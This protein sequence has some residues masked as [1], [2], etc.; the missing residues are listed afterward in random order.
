M[1]T[2]TALKARSSLAGMPIIDVDTHLSERH[3]LWTSRAPASLRDKVPQVREIDGQPT[4]VINGDIS[5]HGVSA[6][7]T[8]LPDLGKAMGWTFWNLQIDQVHAASYDP[9][10]R[11]ALMDQMGVYAQIVYPNV[12]GFGGQRASSAVPEAI[13]RASIELYN[14][15]MA[16]LQADSGERLFPMALMPWWDVKESVKEAERCRKM[17]LRGIN[18]NSDPHGVGLPDLG[19]SHWDPLWEAVVDLDMPVNFHIG[20]SD[21]DGAFYNS[22][23]WP[24]MNMDQKLSITG[25]MMCFGNARVL[26]NMIYSGMFDRHPKLKVVSVESGIGWIP[27]VL[28]ALDYQVTQMQ[29]ESFR[30]LKLK[31]SEYFRRQMYGCFWFEKLDAVHSI[32]VVGEDNVMLETDFPH[33]TSLYPDPLEHV[34]KSLSGLDEPAMAKVVGGNAA[35]VYNLPLG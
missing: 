12:L 2:Q 23:A 1:T 17:G 11:V 14:D 24:S 10:A 16:E 33:P 22:S 13:R 20:A 29:P 26:S 32:K 6:Y 27:F 30:H 4:W 35:R 25:L 34:A 31:P 15:A 3:D 19:Q 7:S 21:E 28:E 18:T 9:K 5:M 8:V